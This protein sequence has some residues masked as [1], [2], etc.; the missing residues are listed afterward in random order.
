VDQSINSHSIKDTER[1]S[2]SILLKQRWSLIQFGVPC[3]VIKILGSRLLV[4]NTLHCR[5]TKSAGFDLSF[6]C[7]NS[8]SAENNNPF[9]SA[10]PTV[11]APS[12]TTPKLR[13]SETGTSPVALNESDSSARSQD[14]PSVHPPRSSPPHST[15]S[16]P[17]PV[18][19]Q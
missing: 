12:H 17:A 9:S 6:S 16:S 19:D 8:V 10:L 7:H 2:E 11:I 13:Q 18:S 14:P 4:R 1:R 5:V 3:E 15:R